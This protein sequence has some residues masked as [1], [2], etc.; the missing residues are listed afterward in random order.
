[1]L[2][3]ISRLPAPASTLASA[4]ALFPN[5]TTL[6]DAAAVAEIAPSKASRAADDLVAAHVLARDG[7]LVFEHPIMRTA[8]YEQLG[9]FGTRA[10]HA[11][12]ADVLLTRAADV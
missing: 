3:R 12:A 4:I 8:V 1:M 2:R 10:G 9:R 7:R 5:G 11:R 6:A